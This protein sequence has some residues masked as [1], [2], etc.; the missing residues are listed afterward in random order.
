M[1]RASLPATISFPRLT[2]FPLRPGIFGYHGQDAELLL[3]QAAVKGEAA[4]IQ[5]QAEVVAVEAVVLG[6]QEDPLG[7]KVLVDLGV[8]LL[9]KVEAA[10]F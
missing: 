4:F 5:A 9:Q 7:Q 1:G 2:C 10:G 8:K 6:V 3:L